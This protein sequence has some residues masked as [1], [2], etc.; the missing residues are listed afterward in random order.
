[1]IFASTQEK[2]LLVETTPLGF[3]IPK[4]NIVLLSSTTNRTLH[5]S[6]LASQARVEMSPVA[7]SSCR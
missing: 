3:N 2:A 5:K 1:M 7:E 4:N 6:A